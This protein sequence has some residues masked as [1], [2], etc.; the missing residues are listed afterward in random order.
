MLED[1]VQK[2]EPTPCFNAL[3]M[4][5]LV[6]CPVRQYLLSLGIDPANPKS[7]YESQ[8]ITHSLHW[9]CPQSIHNQ[10]LTPE[11]G[12]TLRNGLYKQLQNK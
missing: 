1:C 6:I 3:G 2:Y 12:T 4:C 11:Q 7:P 5:A 10:N 9:I 8:K